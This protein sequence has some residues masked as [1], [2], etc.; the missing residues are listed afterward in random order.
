MN[1][2]TSTDLARNL[3]D[4]LNRVRYRGEQFVVQKHGEPIALISPPVSIMGRTLKDIALQ[5]HSLPSPDSDYANDLEI[6]QQ[7]QQPIQDSA[8]PSS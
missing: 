7:M 6:V 8:W 1:T 3:S 2:M 4:V 5:L